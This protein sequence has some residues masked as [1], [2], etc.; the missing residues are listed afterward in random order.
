M[1]LPSGPRALNL[2]P[3][4][5]WGLHFHLSNERLLLVLFILLREKLWPRG[6]GLSTSFPY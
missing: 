5:A 4:P 2:S 3:P 6:H 1:T